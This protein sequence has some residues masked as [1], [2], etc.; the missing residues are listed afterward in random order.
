MLP[1]HKVI[2]C[3]LTPEPRTLSQSTASTAHPHSLG[4]PPPQGGPTLRLTQVL[5]LGGRGSGTGAG[6]ETG[7]LGGSEGATSW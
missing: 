2:T 5:I 1:G 6:E 7:L 4:P 3:S